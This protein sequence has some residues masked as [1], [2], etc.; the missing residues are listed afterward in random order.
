M[1]VLV[2]AIF[3]G[4]VMFL[5]G[6]VA[7]M[8]LGLGNPGIYQPAHE[9]VV[10]SSL[11]EGLGTQSG[12]YIL[13][14][15]DPNMWN[16]KAA[17]AAYAQKS[18]TSPYA[19]VV[20]MPQGQDMTNM[21]RQLPRE[22]ASD[23]LSALMLA[24]LMGL[25]AFGFTKRIAIALA[26]SLFAWLSVLVPYWNWY[27]FPE[28]LALA[29]LVEQVIGWLLAGAVMAWWLGRGERKATG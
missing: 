21:N 13:P 7:H 9:D 1:R 10:I 15:F 18:S 23:T 22:W 11:H 27:R 25:A 28:A 19:W 3:G 4:I 20:Y 14:S 8:V 16:D 26:A 29:A 5:W 12:V 2:A 24:A 17:R 6:F